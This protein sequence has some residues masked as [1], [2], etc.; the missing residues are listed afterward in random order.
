METSVLVVGAGPCGT[1]IA[2]LLGIYGV[3]VVL[4]DRAEDIIDYPRGVGIDDESLRVFQAAGLGEAVH[5]DMIQDQALRW[6]DDDGTP[7]V[8]VAPSAR[9]FGWP[10]RNSFLQPRL[11]RALRDGLNRFPGVGLLTGHTLTNLQQHEDFVEARV[12]RGELPPLTIRA[13]YVI[14]ADGGRSTVRSLV[15]S[16]L[17][18]R[19]VPSRWL[20]VDVPHSTLHAPYS[21]NF[22]SRTRPRVSID[23]PYGYR[24]FEF[25]LN[26]DETESEMLR[27]GAI[28]RLIKTYFDCDTALDG[29]ERARIYTH[30]S[31]IADRF[32]AGRVF[33]AGDAAHLQPPW[34]GQ[35]LNS[36]IRDAANIAWKVAAVVRYGAAPDVL[37]SYELERRS[38]AQAMVDLATTLGKFYSPKT[39][40][41]AL[42][43]RYGLRAARRVP[44]MRDYFLQMRF[45]PMP[46]YRNG[47]VLHRDGGSAS[48]VGRMLIQPDVETADGRR[49]RFDD[50][51][52]PW[53]GIIGINFDPVE[54][55]SPDT[56]G[57]WQRLGAR[58]ARVNRSRAGDHLRTVSDETLLLDDV[59][60]RFRDWVHAKPGCEAIVLRPDRYVAAASTRA[61][62]D[63]VASAF[64]TILPTVDQGVT[65]V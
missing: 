10:R 35:G 63:T 2:N 21:A 17:E 47:V 44:V 40:A 51:I 56:L 5:R 48:V 58:F 59:A 60:G 14:G 13:Q 50:A 23:L 25:R 7:L 49:M 57:H 12:E 37:R 15:G 41:G 18:G 31:R 46:Y 33:L 11:E 43:R 22:I 53:F 6:F 45:K 55:L 38:H 36:G 24:R 1:T 39:R 61:E 20:V 27:P 52:G 54:Y 64:R 42:A 62:L 4:I 16:R 29:T 8:E 32:Q 65:H 28:A 30:H 34:F 9:P 3:D 26:D 19:T